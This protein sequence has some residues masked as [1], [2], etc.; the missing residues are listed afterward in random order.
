MQKLYLPVQKKQDETPTETDTEE[1][2]INVTNVQSTSSEKLMVLEEN[3]R[4]SK[5]EAV[6]LKKENVLLR[7]INKIQSD[8]HAKSMKIKEAKYLQA[9]NIFGEE[10]NKVLALGVLRYGLG[11]NKQVGT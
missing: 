10:H 6:E 8:N 1:G 11:L 4:L 9:I 2:T 7:R 5:L 3:L